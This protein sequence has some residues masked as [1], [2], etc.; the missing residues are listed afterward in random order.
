MYFFGL[1]TAAGLGS[2]VSMLLSRST[3]CC[4]LSLILL[5]LLGWCA[6]VRVLALKQ[7][8]A[9]TTNTVVATNAGNLIAILLQKTERKITAI[10][11]VTVRVK[12]RAELTIALQAAHQVRDGRTAQG[13]K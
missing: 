10:T 4:L 3:T 12:K 7:Q 9:A 6:L 2:P 1:M 13:F 11:M 5:S 8:K